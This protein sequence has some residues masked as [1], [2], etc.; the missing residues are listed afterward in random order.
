MNRRPIN[1]FTIIELMV[2]VVIIALLMAV[3]LPAFSNMLRSSNASLASNKLS[4][5]VEAA[6]DMAVRGGAGDDAA[7]VFFYD[8]GRIRIVPC[9]RVGT[10]GDRDFISGNNGSS[11]PATRDVFVPTPLVE[12]I[13]LPPGWMVRGRA[14]SGWTNQYWYEQ[15]YYVGGGISQDVSHW[16]FPETGF[17]NTG[18]PD[19]GGLRQTF[20]VRFEGGSGRHAIDNGG[21]AVAVDLRPSAEKRS[22][23]PARFDQAPDLGVAVRRALA[24]PALLAYDSVALRKLIGNGSSDSVLVKPVAQLALYE[25][26][27]M[28]GGIGAKISRDTGSIYTDPT[29][30]TLGPSIDVRDIDKWIEGTLPEREREARLFRIS[31]YSGRL[32]EMTGERP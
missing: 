14:P 5:A 28:A 32:E 16:V 18:E 11:V 13:E 31:R 7:A 12:P 19:E 27:A 8:Q 21:D 22:T 15:N 26:R 1:A 20:M 24:D 6:R 30:P 10:F 23:Q 17:Y 3:A 25:E 2:V 9:V 4:T 29:D